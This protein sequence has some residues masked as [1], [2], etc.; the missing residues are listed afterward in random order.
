M[1]VL[2]G[3]IIVLF[4]SLYVSCAPKGSLGIL[5]GGVSVTVAEEIRQEENKVKALKKY[6]VVERIN[7]QAAKRLKKMIKRRDMEVHINITFFRMKTSVF[8]KGVGRIGVDVVV[9]E[10]GRELT[11][12]KTSSTTIKKKTHSVKKMSKDL[13]KKIYKIM[14]DF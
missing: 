12:F 11:T 1:R 13:S 2:K 14:R 8:S 9:K 5:K 4:V 10:A 6:K 3:I 7:K